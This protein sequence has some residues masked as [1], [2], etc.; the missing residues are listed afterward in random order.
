MLTSLFYNNVYYIRKSVYEALYLKY[1]LYIQF[2]KFL[3]YFLP[4]YFK[5]CLIDYLE[6]EMQFIIKTLLLCLKIIIFHTWFIFNNLSDMVCID[7]LGRIRRFEV[8]YLLL[9][10]QYNNRLRIKTRLSELIFIPTLTQVLPAAG[11]FE[12]EIW[13]LFGIFFIGNKDLRRLL[14]DYG[15]CGHPLRKDF[16]LSGFFEV[17][18][19]DT[20]KR[21]IYE[22]TSL[23][24]A[25]RTFIFK[26]TWHMAI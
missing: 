9:S 2:F 20:F 15:F 1:A 21:I 7:Y 10:I 8:I 16:P 22:K 12:R 17:F 23:A 24:Q 26:N 3:Q 4:I 14:N 13:D 6:Y 11:W 19:D 18:Y 25:C 5:R